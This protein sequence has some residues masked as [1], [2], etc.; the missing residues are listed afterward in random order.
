MEQ[1]RNTETKSKR[2]RTRSFLIELFKLL[3]VVLLITVL[4]ALGGVAF[5]IWISYEVGGRLDYGYR[6]SANPRLVHLEIGDKAFAIPQNHIWSQ[7]QWKGGQ[8]HWC[9]HACFATGF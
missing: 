9:E 4:V 8:I 6:P 7:D 2:T 1:K 3:I 5:Y